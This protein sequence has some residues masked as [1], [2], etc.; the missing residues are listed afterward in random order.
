MGLCKGP[1][2]YL[3]E[4]YIKTFI[5]CDSQFLLFYSVWKFWGRGLSANSR[6]YKEHKIRISMDGRGRWMDNV[7]I[8]RLWKSVKYEEVYLKAYDSIAAARQE[9]ID[10]FSFYNRVRRHQGLNKKSPDEVYWKTLPLKIAA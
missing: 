4:S 10:Y 7:F 2:P 9:L 6:I 8:E 3:I 1:S 5:L